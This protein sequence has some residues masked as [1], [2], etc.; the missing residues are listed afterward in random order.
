MQLNFD[1]SVDNRPKKRRLKKWAHKISKAA[2]NEDKDVNE[3]INEEDTCFDNLLDTV[4]DIFLIKYDVYDNQWWFD[5]I[6][7]DWWRTR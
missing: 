3:P 1:G 7:S 2:V 6:F 4:H 5:I